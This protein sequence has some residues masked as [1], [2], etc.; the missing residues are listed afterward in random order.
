MA[1]QNVGTLTTILNGI[2]AKYLE[3]LNLHF[4]LLQLVTECDFK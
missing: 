3:F 2:T 1:F 4:V